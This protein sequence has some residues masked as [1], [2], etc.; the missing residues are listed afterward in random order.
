MADYERLDAAS[1][2][3]RKK[4]WPSVRT[5]TIDQEF[6]TEYTKAYP[7]PRFRHSCLKAIVV[8]DCHAYCQ[9]CRIDFLVSH[10]GMVDV[11]KNPLRGEI[12]MVCERPLRGTSTILRQGI[13]N[14]DFFVNCTTHTDI[15]IDRL[16]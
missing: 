1:T 5:K 9:W 8:S 16:I 10:S 7:M 3:P 6:K 11:K 14:K 15:Y 13:N 2:P 4:Q 12:A